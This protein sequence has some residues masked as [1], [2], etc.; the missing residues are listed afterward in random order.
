[1]PPPLHPPVPWR[2]V[3]GNDRPVE[4]EIGPGRGDILLAWARA[5]PDTNFFAVEHA[6]GIATALADRAAA[7]GLHNVRVIGGDARCVVERLVAADSV[8]AYHIYFPDPWP[9]TRH[10]RR[11][12]FTDRA[13]AP[14][15]R[16][17][18]RP[19][20]RLHL[21]SDLPKLHADMCAALVAAGFV[22]DH[23]AP[24]PRDRPI[25]KFERKY[26]TAGTW[27][28]CFRRE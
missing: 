9:K 13:F 22:R 23:A 7:E 27:Y 10:R 6:S 20:G 26:A 4:F 8:A 2:D 21:A 15:L 5:L 12:L 1:M 16:R 19:D 14:A 24:P 28:A 25:T 17:T 3:F 18:L 11:R